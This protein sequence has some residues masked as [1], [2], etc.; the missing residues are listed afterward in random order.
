MYYASPFL[1]THRGLA[2][3]L[4]PDT[5]S[6][7]LEAAAEER[8][9]GSALRRHCG[10]Y[11]Q[12]PR[13]TPPLAAGRL[14]STA[15]HFWQAPSSVPRHHEGPPEVPGAVCGGAAGAVSP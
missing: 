11:G 12:C 8:P 1:V 9:A 13:N 4:A 14:L 15:R 10:R 5:A 3:L 6:A 7:D 2:V